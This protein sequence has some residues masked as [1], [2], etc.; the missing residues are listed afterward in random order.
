MTGLTPSTAYQWKVKGDC[1]S[2]FVKFTTSAQ[3]LDDLSSNEES[4]NSI[5]VYPNPAIVTMNMDVVMNT[6]ENRE[7]TI[8]LINMLGQIVISENDVITGGHLQ[9]TL[10]V[11]NELFRSLYSKSYFRKYYDG[12]T[13]SY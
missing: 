10:N 4:Q 8:Q 12:R 5:S 11:G 7:A 1:W 9:H 3:K 13:S 2:G 6:E